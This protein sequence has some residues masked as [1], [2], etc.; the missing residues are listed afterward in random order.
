VLGDGLNSFPINLR[1]F[2]HQP[3]GEANDQASMGHSLRET[4]EN[5]INLRENGRVIAGVD[6]LHHGRQAVRFW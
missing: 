3:I 1:I 5:A 4:L 2:V 6:R